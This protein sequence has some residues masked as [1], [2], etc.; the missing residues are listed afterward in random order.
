MKTALIL[1]LLIC[2]CF[3]PYSFGSDTVLLIPD[4]RHAAEAPPEG[5]CGEVSIQMASL[6]YGAF[7]KQYFIHHL[8]NP[9]HPDLY[10][11]E[12]PG[13][14]DALQIEYEKW[15][16]SNNNINQFFNWMTQ[17]ISNDYPI[18]FGAKIY[19][20]YHPEWF[21]DHFMIAKGYTETS[22][23]YNTNWGYEE[24]KSF[25]ALSSTSTT[26]ISI[27]NSYK[28]YLGIAIKGFKKNNTKSYPLHFY[29]ENSTSSSISGRIKIDSLTVGK[30]YTLLRFH[31]LSDI[32]TNRYNIDNAEEF[33]HFTATESS[34][35]TNKDISTSGT[36]IF[37]CIAY[38]IPTIS[39]KQNMDVRIYPN[40]TQDRLFI[41]SPE[42][43]T[44]PV[45]FSISNSLGK[46]VLVGKLYNNSIDTSNLK[47][48]V[49][50]IKITK[51]AGTVTRKIIIQ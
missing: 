42:I 39:N 26:G 27:E 7:F 3:I 19:P 24:E 30:K 44:H 1:G 20:T 29:V 14:L 6:Y 17:N 21:L 9:D 46:E 35:T 32:K 47:P 18:F 45:I 2:T 16:Y 23:I 43:N 36:C 11:Y 5:W 38:T 41:D 25:D 48:G 4:R 8:T 50:F 10:A 33:E 31:Q 49:Y 34:Y 13:T 15:S 22:L 12:I 28:K 37:V 40:P 51:D